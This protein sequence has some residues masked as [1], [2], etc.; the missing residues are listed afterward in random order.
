LREINPKVAREISQISSRV[1]KAARIDWSHSR[2]HDTR[3]RV[4]AD[5]EEEFETVSRP[6]M[7]QHEKKLVAQSSSVLIKI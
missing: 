1:I 2:T 3:K 6:G 5:D 7:R 4:N